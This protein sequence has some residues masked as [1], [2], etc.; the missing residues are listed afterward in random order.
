MSPG[1]IIENPK[2][3]KES[4]PIEITPIV[5]KKI[6]TVFL[7]Q[8]KPDSKVAKPRC[9]KNTMAVAIKIQRFETVKVILVIF[10][11]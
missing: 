3:A 6:L 10:R 11:F 1:Y 4:N 5:L 9:I 8:V 2:K 7:E